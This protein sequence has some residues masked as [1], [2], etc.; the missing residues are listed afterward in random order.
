MRVHISEMSKKCLENS[1]FEI[2]FRGLVE[3]KVS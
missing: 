1:E 3:L 2:E